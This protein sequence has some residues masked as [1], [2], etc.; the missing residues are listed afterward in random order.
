MRLQQCHFECLIMTY[1]YFC[2]YI[3]LYRSG[4]MSLSVVNIWFCPVILPINVEG[5]AGYS[6]W[7]K[8][9]IP[10]TWE[11]SVLTVSF[12][13][14]RKLQVAAKRNSTTAY[15]NGALHSTVLHKDGLDKL[16]EITIVKCTAEV[17]SCFCLPQMELCMLWYVMHMNQCRDK[18]CHPQFPHLVTSQFVSHR[19][20]I[21]FKWQLEIFHDNHGHSSFT[22]HLFTLAQ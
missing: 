15:G 17:W 21:V 13:I 9:C 18:I 8:F 10:Q 7:G 2:M 4:Y 16:Q 1:F 3:S 5:R 19:V 22:F 6:L 14:F 20:N 11:G 12:I